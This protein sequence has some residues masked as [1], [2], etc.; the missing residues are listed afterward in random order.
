[1]GCLA[2]LAG[3]PGVSSQTTKGGNDI[4]IVVHPDTPI[5]DLKM[6]EVRQIFRG[7]RQYWSKNIPVVLIM[8]APVSREREAVLRTI[9]QMNDSQFKQYW[10]G[11]IFRAETTSA[12]KIVYSNTMASQL[13]SAVPGAIAFMDAKD[14]KP[15]LKV[16]AINGILPGQAN[17]PIR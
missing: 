11:K 6:E 7:D 17:Y 9:F 4:A 10:V 1:M 15:G 16:V 2:L 5:T 8:R 12:P 14:L 3:A 13:V